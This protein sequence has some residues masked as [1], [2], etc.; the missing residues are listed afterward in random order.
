[1]EFGTYKRVY[2]MEE[3]R[4][5]F[6]SRY[7]EGLHYFDKLGRIKTTLPKHII[8]DWFCI[9]SHVVHEGK[10]DYSLVKYTNSKARVRIICPIHGEF[11]QRPADH[12]NSGNGCPECGTKSTADKRRTSW[13]DL[14]YQANL[15]FS[16]KF[17]YEP[18]EEF[19]RIKTSK[20]KIICPEHGA[21]ESYWGTH[22]ISHS[23][24]PGC[25]DYE[26]KQQKV[27]ILQFG[28]FV[29]I[30]ISCNVPRRLRELRGSGKR[31]WE[32]IKSF[33][34]P[35]SHSAYYY[36][37]RLH[38][39]FSKYRTSKFSGEDGATEIFEMTVDQVLSSKE[40]YQLK[41]DNGK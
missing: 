6:M 11:S 41:E 27:Y 8:Q 2:D 37:Q 26:G 22:L 40:F 38:K 36:E 35:D 16:H 5:I 9:R 19:K 14:V 34:T 23:G 15:K 18:L 20:I 29:K 3:A 13:E 12:V 7:P 24:C 10:Y 30:G 28:S 17:T 33:E 4:S 31:Q 21:H 39:E 32:L 1:M 25:R